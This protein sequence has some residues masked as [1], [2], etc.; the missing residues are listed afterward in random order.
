MVMAIPYWGDSPEL[1][2]V[3][4][5]G[6][7]KMPGT[8]RVTG[9]VSRKV[10]V[11]PIP[12]DESGGTQT[13]LGYEGAKINVTVRMWTQAHLDAYEMFASHFRPKKDD[14]KPAPIDVIHPALGVVGIRSLTVIDVGIPEPAQQPGMYEAT[15]ELIEFI[16]EVKKGKGEA[17]TLDASDTDISSNFTIAGASKVFADGSTPSP[18]TKTGAATPIGPQVPAP[19]APALPAA[20]TP[21]PFSFNVPGLP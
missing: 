15:V 5:M 16:S 14:K 20:T 2:D 4:K 1:W 19:A 8:A 9:K 11:Q 18:N 12:G 6:G 13:D 7:I 17:K 21:N 3:V 10:D